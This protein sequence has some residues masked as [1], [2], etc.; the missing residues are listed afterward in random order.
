MS[1]NNSAAPPKGFGSDAGTG[2]PERRLALMDAKIYG[3]PPPNLNFR[4][5]YMRHV[6]MEGVSIYGWLLADACAPDLSLSGATLVGVTFAGANLERANFGCAT[7][8][9]VPFAYYKSVDEHSELVGARV[10]GAVFDCAK[11][12]GDVSFAGADLSYASFVGADLSGADLNDA[13]LHWSVWEPAV[14]PKPEHIAY[15]KRL[16]TLRFENAEASVA[17]RK[18]LLDAGFQNAAQQVNAAIRSHGDVNAPLATILFGIT[19][20]YGASPSR[21]LYLVAI[22]WLFMASLYWSVLIDES[23]VNGIWLVEDRAAPGAP[24]DVQ[25]TR[26]GHPRGTPGEI[27]GDLKW[28]LLFSLRTALSLGFKDFAFDRWIRALTPRDYE[29]SARGAVRVLAGIQALISIY[30]LTLAALSYFASPFM[31]G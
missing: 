9:T 26:L 25:A 27:C 10:T 29:F 15:A 6:E 23:P 24:P 11:F 7:L 8:T 22:L 13:D 1:Q 18:S 3:T 17:L 30:L 21:P 19:C 2:C 5:A 28:A 12:V 14:N 31:P 16:D 4:C 20:N